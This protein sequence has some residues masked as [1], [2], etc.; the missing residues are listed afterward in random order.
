M[1]KI[2]VA[3]DVEIQ[4][5]HKLIKVLSK[6]IEYYKI[7][8]KLFTNNPEILTEINAL[9]KKVFLDLKYHDIPS[10]VGLA[11]KA[12]TEK[13]KPF[14]I[15]LHTSGG[16]KMM[17]EAVKAK[18]DLAKD[19]RPLLFGVT[20]LTSLGAEDLKA[21]YGITQ[22]LE[23]VVINLAKTARTCGLDGIVCSGRE[24][25]LVKKEC[26]KEFLTLV[27]GVQLAA[28]NFR[29]DQNRTASIEDLAG[30]GD[31]FVLGRQITGASNPAEM[32]G[33]ILNAIK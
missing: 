9:G 19:L 15:T 22:P 7:G 10:V 14:A 29:S 20:V 6:E 18:N 27:P 1:A 24:L 3:L 13:Y 33:K 17:Q 2:V 31:Y 26:G 32:A 30:I 4:D 11:I 23:D 21:L 8:H 12:V 16:P 28:E 25:P 5:A